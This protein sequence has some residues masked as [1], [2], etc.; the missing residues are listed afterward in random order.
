MQLQE[1]TILILLSF[2]FTPPFTILTLYS[3][4]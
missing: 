4:I 2:S 3:G 1:M